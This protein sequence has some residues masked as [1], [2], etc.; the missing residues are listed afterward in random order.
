[1]KITNIKWETDGEVDTSLPFEMEVPDGLKT[2]EEV[3]NYLSDETGFLVSSYT[4]DI[5]KEMKQEPFKIETPA[6]KWYEGYFTNGRLKQDALPLG[7]HKYDLMESDGDD[8]YAF[9]LIRNGN[10]FVNH[11]GTFYM[12]GLIEE[13]KENGSEGEIGEEKWDYSFS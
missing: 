6:G 2:P 9:C 10:V 4:I 3:D 13:L 8:K 5:P 1:M 11:G 12:Y 7:W